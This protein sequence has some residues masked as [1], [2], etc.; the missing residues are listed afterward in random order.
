M[1]LPVSW[2]IGWWFS[3]WAKPPTVC[4]AVVLMSWTQT[5]PRLW[6]DKTVKNLCACKHGPS[7]VS[8][9]GFGSAS[10]DDSPLLRSSVGGEVVHSAVVSLSGRFV[11]SSE[12][13]SVCCR[14][15][16]KPWPLERRPSEVRRGRKRAASYLQTERSERCRTRAACCEDDWGQWIQHRTV[17]KM[18]KQVFISVLRWRTGQM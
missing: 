4:E 15:R 18:S 11:A 1:K 3:R 16:V 14:R 12:K 6:R 2:F 8:G 17:S 13:G 10:A 9:P 7:V 5:G